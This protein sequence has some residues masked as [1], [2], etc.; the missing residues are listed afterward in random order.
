[1]PAAGI[2]TKQLGCHGCTLVRSGSQ[3]AWQT[4]AFL[5]EKAV[6]KS[7]VLSCLS[8]AEL[9]ESPAYLYGE[10]N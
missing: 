5:G 6:Q 10:M 8:S 9:Q 4:R 3:Q 7:R 1:M 2:D